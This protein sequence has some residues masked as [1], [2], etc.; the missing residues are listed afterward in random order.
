MYVSVI[1]LIFYVLQILPIKYMQENLCGD[2]EFVMK[3][4]QK[5]D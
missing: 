2:N 1:Q 3:R 4:L 5:L